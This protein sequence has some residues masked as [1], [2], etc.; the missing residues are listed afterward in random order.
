MTFPVVASV[1][2]A[3]NN[4][5]AGTSHVID[6]PDNISSGDLLFAFFTKDGSTG[7]T[8]WPATLTWTILTDASGAGTSQ[9]S[10]R[11]RIAGASE[12]TDITIAT[13]ASEEAIGQ[14][15]RI[16]GWHGTTPPAAG[17]A[18]TGTTSATPDPP[19]LDPADWATE[20]TLWVAWFGCNG[21]GVVSAYPTNYT[22]N[23]T[24]IQQTAIGVGF[25]TRE[26]AAA[27]DD[28]GTFTKGSSTPWSANTFAIRPAAAAAEEVPYLTVAVGAE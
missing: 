19:S 15:L 20:D 12:G 9:H 21:T 18:V 10:V 6:L 7:S 23:Q 24:N 5:T 22:G 11:Y 16:T 25:A 27:S 2:T 26:F 13:S 17:T 14:I 3:Y 1:G 28:P 4:A 8:T